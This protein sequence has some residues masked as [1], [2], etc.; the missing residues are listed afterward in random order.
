M[1][2][3][4]RGSHNLAHNW[5]HYMPIVF[6]FYQLSLSRLSLTKAVFELIAN[7]AIQSIHA[8]MIKID[9]DIKKVKLLDFGNFFNRL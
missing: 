5:K 2:F 1:C 7:N 8:Y 6:C 3:F 9:F 4:I